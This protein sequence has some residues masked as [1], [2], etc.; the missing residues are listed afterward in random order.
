MSTSRLVHLVTQEGHQDLTCSLGLRWVAG[1]EKELR[2]LVD[3][4]RTYNVELKEVL[5]YCKM[6]TF[7]R[8]V[9]LVLVSSRHLAAG[10][11]AARSASHLLQAAEEDEQFRPVVLTT[12]PQP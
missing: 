12:G 1:D 5:P 10:I 3:G 8:R 6:A 7:E 9:G 11:A 2:Q 4:L